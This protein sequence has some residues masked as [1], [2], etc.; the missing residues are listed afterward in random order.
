MELFYLS[1]Y[2]LYDLLF[3]LNIMFVRSMHIEHIFVVLSFLCCMVFS[4]TNILL[5]ILPFY[6]MGIL[7]AGKNILRHVS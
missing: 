4:S 1:T 6:G 7:V 5:F 3:K 2:L